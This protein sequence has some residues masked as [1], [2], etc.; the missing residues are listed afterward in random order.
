MV[1]FENID[2]DKAILKNSDVNIDKVILKNVNIDKTIPKNIDIDRK[3]L[4]NIDIDKGIL[5][6]WYNNGS[7]W[8]QNPSIFVCVQP[9]LVFFLLIS[10]WNVDIDKEICKILISVKYCIN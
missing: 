10:W 5:K 3:S 1:I 2:I 4:R 6:C 7:K 8:V 9:I